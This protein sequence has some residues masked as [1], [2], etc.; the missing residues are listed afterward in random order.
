MLTVLT[1]MEILTLRRIKSIKL[2]D[3][4]NPLGCPM[5]LQLP[6]TNQNTDTFLFFVFF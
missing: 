6:A 1:F 2:E 5:V 3:F 4:S